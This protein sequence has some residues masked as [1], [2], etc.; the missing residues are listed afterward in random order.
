MSYDKHARAVLLPPELESLLIDFNRNDQIFVKVPYA[1]LLKHKDALISHALGNASDLS[2]WHDIVRNPHA[3]AHVI[4][5]GKVVLEVPPILT[6]LP[7]V[8]P[9]HASMTLTAAAQRHEREIDRLPIAAE[10][11]LQRQLEDYPRPKGSDEYGKN[12]WIKLLETFD[13]IPKQDTVSTTEQ[14][15]DSDSNV[16]FT[17]D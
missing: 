13:A 14:A 12:L 11:K 3:T 10:R 4:K 9:P 15:D 8:N 17:F 5:D 1:S 2:G 16:E 7:T 6:R